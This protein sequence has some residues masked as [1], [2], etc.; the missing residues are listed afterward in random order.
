LLDQFIFPTPRQLP[1]NIILLSGYTRSNSSFLFSLRNKESLA[2][3]I[4][5]LIP[6]HKQYAIYC[7]P[8]YGLSSGG[9]HDVHMCAAKTTGCYFE[10]IRSML[11]CILSIIWLSNYSIRHLEDI[12]RQALS[13]VTRIFRTCPKCSLS[14]CG[15]GSQFSGGRMS[16]SLNIFE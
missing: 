9:S 10:S 16:S 3:F 11:I 8:N 4:A 13:P 2:P 6:D 14:A 15:G 5:N 12:T 7:L 1:L